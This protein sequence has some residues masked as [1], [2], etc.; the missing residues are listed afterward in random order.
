MACVS[1]K[2]YSAIERGTKPAAVGCTR[3][4]ETS[5]WQATKVY[6]RQIAQEAQTRCLAGFK[7]LTSVSIASMAPPAGGPATRR[8]DTLP[9]SDHIYGPAPSSRAS[10]AQRRA[11]S[12]STRARRHP[13]PPSTHCGQL[14]ELV[15][16]KNS[17]GWACTS[18]NRTRAICDASFH[19]RHSVLQIGISLIDRLCSSS[20]RTDALAPLGA[21]RS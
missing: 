10:R 12:G 1:S 2:C 3:C 13:L 15:K 17:A 20:C 5:T 16:S 21:H 8:V 18:V 11:F 14:S 6:A 4:H 7:C 19:G 9:S